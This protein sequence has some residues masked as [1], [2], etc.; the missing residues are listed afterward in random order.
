MRATVPAVERTWQ[1]AALYVVWPDKVGRVPKPESTDRVLRGVWGE[2]AEASAALGGPAGPSPRGRT[3]AWWGWQPGN[4]LE[5]GSAGAFRAC[6]RRLGSSAGC[7]GGYDQVA[8][9]IWSRA[10]RNSFCQGQR[11]G[12]CRVS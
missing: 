7:S 4:R 10:P 5:P 8:A 12:R 9:R 2:A 6:W 3:G 1:P 11:W